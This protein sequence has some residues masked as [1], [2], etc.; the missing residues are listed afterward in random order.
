MTTAT[1]STIITLILSLF[2][3]APSFAQKGKKKSKAKT[4]KKATPKKETVSPEELMRTYR[5]EEA[6]KELRR[7][8]NQLGEYEDYTQTRLE[9]ALQRAQIGEAMLQ[10]IEKVIIV[11]SLVVDRESFL[12]HLSLSEGAGTIG[13]P[14]RLLPELTNV[15]QGNT[16][17]INDF[18]D[19]AIFSAS[20][21]TGFIKLFMSYNLGSKWSAPEQ[22]PGMSR[23]DAIQDYPFVLPDGVTL[24]YAAQGE[25]SLGGYDIFVTRYNK[26]SGEYV[27][28]ANMGMPFNS[29]ANDFMMVIDETVGLGWFVTDRNQPED[30]VCIYCFIPNESR[31]VYDFDSENSNTLRRLAQI[32][33]IAESQTDSAK[34][35]E[36]KKRLSNRA[37]KP[38]KKPTAVFRYVINDERVYTALS[39]FRSPEARKAAEQVV[40]T[41]QELQETTAALERLRGEYAKNRHEAFALEIEIKEKK[42]KQLR[43]TLKVA[44]KT[45]R[46]AELNIK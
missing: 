19:T 21:S 5:F 32:A 16:A 29:P 10:G 12:Q 46:Q 41:A 40:A 17:Y 20:D 25:E 38:A 18:E 8:L 45:M 9:M 1:R 31:E 30:K 35:A 37:K 39:Q 22:M 42:A 4:Q 11:D 6:A 24:Y 15:A 43:E 44:E 7:E 3:L 14:K 26:E 34:V 23:T 2:I 36:A 28:A 27:K 13:T 33:S